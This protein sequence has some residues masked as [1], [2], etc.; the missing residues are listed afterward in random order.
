VQQGEPLQVLRYVPGQEYRS[1]LDALP[2]SQNQRVLT[3][4]V[5]L[6]DGYEGGETSFVRTGLKWK[7][8]KGDALLFRN[9]GE[10]ERPDPSSQH[11]GLP[12]TRGTKIIA[13]RW[14]RAKPIDLYKPLG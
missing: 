7:G 4:L 13:S 3:M 12:V 6:N 8:R 1:H 2:A 11:A 14:I 9:A 10:D 5:C